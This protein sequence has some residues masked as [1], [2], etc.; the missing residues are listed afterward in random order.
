MG[1]PQ[2]SVSKEKKYWLLLL[3]FPPLEGNNKLDN[4]EGMKKNMILEMQYA[5]EAT[6]ATTCSNKRD[7]YFTVTET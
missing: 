2:H 4:N 1:I 3:F 5:R 7:I 6:A